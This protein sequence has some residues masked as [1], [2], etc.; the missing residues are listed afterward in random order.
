MISPHP[1]ITAQALVLMTSAKQVG[2]PDVSASVSFSVKEVAMWQP[3][4]FW[5]AVASWTVSF[6]HCSLSSN[7][8]TQSMDLMLEAGGQVAQSVDSLTV[9]GPFLLSVFCI[10]SPDVLHLLLQT[11]TGVVLFAGGDQ[12]KRTL[13]EVIWNTK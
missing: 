2:Y 4:L 6:M 1:V 5:A 13:Q 8:L 9:A 3:S 12:L 7:Q 10:A 11:H